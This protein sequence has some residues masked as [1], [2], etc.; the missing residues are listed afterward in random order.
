MFRM[1]P[2]KNSI[3]GY[4]WGSK[5]AIQ[6]LLNLPE[7]SRG[8]P[9]AELW[10]GA[11]P[12][13]PSSVFY[14][15]EWRL[16]DGLIAQDPEAIL[17]KA[18]CDLYGGKLPFLFKVLAAAQPLSIQV[19]PD[20]DRA[21]Q[22]FLRENRQGLD[23]KN[24]ARCYKDDSHKPELLCALTPFRAL[25]GFRP[26]HEALGYLETLVPSSLSAELDRLRDS[27]DGRGLRA[28]YASLLGLSNEKREE[29][30]REAAQNARAGAAENQ[31]FSW[32]GRLG[33]AY[34]GDMGMLSP[35]IMNL[36]L[37]APGEA[38]FIDANELHAYLDGV[39]VEVMANSD[40]V[41]RGGLTPKHVDTAQLL[42]VVDFRPG[43]AGILLPEETGPNEKTYPCEAREFLLNAVSVTLDHPL[44]IK[45]NKGLEIFLCVDG[46]GVFEDGLTREEVSFARGESIL[47]A[48]CVKD[49]RLTGA[50]S[51]YRVSVPILFSGEERIPA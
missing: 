34:P 8:T 28:F 18:V 22:G 19:H 10:M 1:G 24:P 38:L 39:G 43:H 26:V 14:Q 40:N 23:L 4:A 20:R 50:A 30:A 48:A 36:I 35:A 25:K 9:M 29:V 17:G 3:Q 33:T 51:L 45:G 7:E 11:H 2:L 12:L 46:E 31:V 21:A 44:E 47:V 41:I 5:T 42:E 49:Y 27:P 37:L 6:D 13:A 32:V 15:G 16:L